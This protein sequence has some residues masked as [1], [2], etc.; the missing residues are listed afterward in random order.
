M[1]NHVGRHIEREQQTWARIQAA[2][3]SKLNGAIRH[4]LY[5][6]GAYVCI[7]IIEYVLAVMSQS[8]TLRADAFNNVSGIIS[9]IL[10]VIGLYIAKDTDAD[11]FDRGITDGP[12]KV[13]GVTPERARLTRFRA[14]TIFTLVTS[15]IMIGIAVSVIVGGIRGLMSPAT[16]VIPEPIALVGA[17][18]ASIIMLVVWYF[19]RQ[20]GRK[21]Q[22]AAL[23]ASSQDSL[24]DAF[25]SIGTMLSIGGALV[26]HLT[27][28]DGVASVIVGVF[29]LA[30]GFKIFRDSSLNLADYFDPHV[31]SQFRDEIATV[32]GVRSV[33]ELKAHYS[34]NLVTLEV[35]IFVDAMIT[36]LASYEIGEQIERRMRHQFGVI[37]T[38]VATVPDP[39]T[40]P[41]HQ[42]HK[43]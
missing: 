38:S 11:S 40:I 21:L 1:K 13:A 42:R 19:N 22:N 8:Q 37:D 30:A 43:E 7:A 33:V 34:G 17:G 5:N 4:L 41:A 35:T 3:I 36:T 9:T 31:E 15:I 23:T 26:F 25:T 29:I 12:E 14:E 20:A 16:R 10:L 18:L 2:E 28:L 6:V 39:A 27:W 24:S 32:P